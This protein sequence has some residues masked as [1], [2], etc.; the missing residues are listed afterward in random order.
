MY[1]YLY[2]MWYGTKHIVTLVYLLYYSMIYIFRLYM[3]VVQKKCQTHVAYHAKKHFQSCADRMVNKRLKYIV[4][5]Y[6]YYIYI[7]FKNKLK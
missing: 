5:I 4:P 2:I 6:T 3:N 7:L 1:K